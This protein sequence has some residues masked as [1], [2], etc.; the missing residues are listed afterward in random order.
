MHQLIGKI[1]GLI[2][3]GAL[4]LGTYLY[5]YL[6]FSKPVEIAVEERGPLVLIYKIH[7][8]A[9]HQ[10]GP[11]IQD[12]EKWARE[13]QIS[14]PLTFG[15]FLDDPA[16]VDQ[17]RLRSHAGCVLEKEAAVTL[18]EDFN[19]E[20]RPRRHYVVGRFSGSP[21][22]GPFK[23]YP[24]IK[25][26]LQTERLKSSSLAVIETY[27]IRDKNVTTEFLFPIEPPNR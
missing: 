25:E 7:T 6:G 14:C 27:L 18:P 26:Y 16:A 3:L 24:K 11:A 22:I 17:D 8:G 1:L 13:N 5:I 20:V 12:V 10:I 2:V 15:E 4:G 19:Q 9:Y 23:V 21:S